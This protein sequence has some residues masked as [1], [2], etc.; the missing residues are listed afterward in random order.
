MRWISSALSEVVV[1]STIFDSAIGGYDYREGVSRWF[2]QF[3]MFQPDVGLM[4]E[5]PL[6]P[7]TWLVAL[8]WAV[9][10]PVFGLLF[11]WRGEGTYGRG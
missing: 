10:L 8:G 7:T 11:F 6:D 5:A 9:V 3:W 4:A 1:Y 2:R